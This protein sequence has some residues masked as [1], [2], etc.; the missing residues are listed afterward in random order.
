MR[1]VIA[2]SA[3][4]ILATASLPAS[5]IEYSVAAVSTTTTGMNGASKT[6]YRYTFIPDGVDF[7]VDQALDIEFSSSVF[8][9]LSSGSAGSA[10]D[11]LLLQPNNPPQA[12]GIFSALATVSSP[13]LQT[14][15]V[16]AL[17][18]GPGLPGPL[19]YSINQFNSQGAF[20]R[21]ISS[22]TTV[23]VPASTPEPSTALLVVLAL[24][25]GSS[26]SVLRKKLNI[27]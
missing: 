5:T 24:A 6:L 22:G 2:L 18:I 20:V 21:S 10:F 14:I 12:P 26:A 8:S 9:E 27:I 4:A 15:S 23:P 11:L 13:S 7:Q 3:L 1:T 16:N 19:P 25:T 17:F